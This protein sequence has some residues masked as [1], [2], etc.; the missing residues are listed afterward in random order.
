MMNQ[1]T[2]ETTK[3]KAKS[4]SKKF[5]WSLQVLKAQNGWPMWNVFRRGSLQF[6][7]LLDKKVN[8]AIRFQL[9]QSLINRVDE[10][11]VVGH[12]EDSLQRHHALL[13]NIV[14]EIPLTVC[15]E[16]QN[17]HN[18]I[19]HNAFE[20]RIECFSPVNVLLGE[21]KNVFPVKGETKVKSQNI[22]HFHLRLTN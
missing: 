18:K 21:V 22:L 7:V 13:S 4:I 5:K 11:E 17:V 3:T 14:C 6:Q 20:V 1:L 9:L 10:V 16:Y 15:I 19:Y 12:V 8:E 2:K